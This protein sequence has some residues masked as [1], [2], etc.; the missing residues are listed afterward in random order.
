MRQFHD[1]QIILTKYKQIT[2][3]Y[4]NLAKMFPNRGEGRNTGWS[5]TYY[6][7]KDS[8]TTLFISGWPDG[9]FWAIFGKCGYFWELFSKKKICGY[10]LVW[11]LF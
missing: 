2:N 9:Y 1:N 8:L 10:S 7:I 4:D 6:S 11:W 5:G 3:W